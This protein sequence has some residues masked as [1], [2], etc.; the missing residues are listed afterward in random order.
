[1][2]TGSKSPSKCRKRC[3]ASGGV[4]EN[5]IKSNGQWG[6]A[7]WVASFERCMVV[8]ENVKRLRKVFGC[9]RKMTIVHIWHR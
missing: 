2:I 5:L 7:Q 1:M 6:F 8:N 9:H 4:H 3:A